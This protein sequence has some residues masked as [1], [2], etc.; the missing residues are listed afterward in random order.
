MTFN[1]SDVR[2]GRGIDLGYGEMGTITQVMHQDVANAYAEK[3]CDR[4]ESERIFKELGYDI[5]YDSINGNHES[6]VHNISDALTSDVYTE[7]KDILSNIASLNSDFPN[8]FVLKH[9]RSFF[10][11]ISE[12]G[13]EA[14]LDE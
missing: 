13:T 5:D 2:G 4:S 11:N 1:H 7:L 14:P 9:A 3:I 8:S 12:Q 6:S 10:W